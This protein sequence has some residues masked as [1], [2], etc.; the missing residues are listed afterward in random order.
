MKNQKNN[1]V[2][3][4]IEYVCMAGTVYALLLYLLWSDVDRLRKTYFF[5]G[6]GIDK[7]IRERFDNYSYYSTNRTTGWNMMKRRFNKIKLRLF[8]RC[9]FPFL[10]KAQIFAQDHVYFAPLLIRNRQYTLLEDGVNWFSIHMRKDSQTYMRMISYQNSFIGRLQSLFLGSLSTHPYGISKQCLRVI[11]SAKDDSPALQGKEVVVLDMLSLWNDSDDE[12][13]EFI[14]HLFGI[15]SDDIELLCDKSTILFTQPFFSDNILTK[16]EH[17]EVYKDIISQ[18]QPDKLVIKTH[19]RDK[20]PY[21]E[22]FNDVLVFDK[23]VPMELLSMIGINFSKAVTICST[24]V[25]TIPY[26]VEIVWIGSNIHP[27]IFEFFGDDTKIK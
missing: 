12:K 10:K 1:I 5:F 4:N 8:S 21:R 17:Y 9:M 15:S 20:F 19:P 2:T 14:L 6:D 26:E 18:I 7:S 24:V 16:I 27:K 11:L 3:N 25:Y 23:P 13:K 22:F